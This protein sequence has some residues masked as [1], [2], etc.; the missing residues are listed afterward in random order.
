M[1]DDRTDLI[2]KSNSC[3]MGCLPVVFGIAVAGRVV[4]FSVI[5]FL[6]GPQAALDKFHFETLLGFIIVFLFAALVGLISIVVPRLRLI[7]G[8]S[9]YGAGIVLLVLLWIN[10]FATLQIFWG[11]FWLIVGLILGVIGV[12]PLAIIALIF[13]G[14]WLVVSLLVIGIIVTL[15]LRFLGAYAMS[16][17]Q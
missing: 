14:A 16:K 13:K 1:N 2:D 6:K 3:F 15:G 17:C 12:I 4:W 9:L 10:S 5:A 8:M 7:A 11:T